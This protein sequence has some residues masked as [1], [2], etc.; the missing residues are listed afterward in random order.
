MRTVPAGLFNSFEYTL[1]LAYGE[2]VHRYTTARAE[3]TLTDGVYTPTNMIVALAPLVVSN[4]KQSSFDFVI[5]DP[6]FE[7]LLQSKR[8]LLG[9]TIE[10]RVVNGTDSMLLYKGRISAVNFLRKTAEIGEQLVKV[11]CAP[12]LYGSQG[13]NP[14][15]LTRESIRA[16]D[17]SDSCCDDLHTVSRKIVAKWGH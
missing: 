8:G 17:N 7:A 6:D 10:A 14:F 15:K 4:L 16:R 12:P 3:V 13:S 5:S 11:T 2:G 9:A 1:K